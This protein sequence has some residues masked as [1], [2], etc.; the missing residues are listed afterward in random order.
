MSLTLTLLK[1]IELVQKK[2]ISFHHGRTDLT[3]RPGNGGPQAISIGV[4][5]DIPESGWDLELPKL[6]VDFWWATRGASLLVVASARD[7]AVY[8]DG[9]VLADKCPPDVLGTFLQGVAIWEKYRE[10][11]E[12]S[13]L[14]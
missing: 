8:E 9:A 10:G 1:A 11:M 14:P 2:R 6:P 12:E 4:F 13:C 3:L 7:V 5:L